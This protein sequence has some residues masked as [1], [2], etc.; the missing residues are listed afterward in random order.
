MIN[1]DFIPIVCLLYPCFD[2]L[3]NLYTGAYNVAI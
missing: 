1:R 2:E 3:K